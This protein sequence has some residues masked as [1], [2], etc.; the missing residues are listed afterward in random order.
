MTDRLDRI[1]AA[2]A[3][4]KLDALLIGA[5]VEDMFGRH[6]DNRRYVSGFTGSTGWALVTPSQAL[7]AA[8][9]RYTEQAEREVAPRGFT[10]FPA[11]GTSK[12]WWPKLFG[13]ARLAG[14][15]VGVSRSDISLASWLALNERIE[16]MPSLDRPE[17][18]AAPLIV[19][20]LRRRKDPEELVLLQHA[21]DIADQAFESLQ[22][23]LTP[24]MT[25]L[26]AAAIFEQNVLALGA[27]SIS[28]ETIVA[29]GPRAAMP[30]AKP[31]DARL[32]EGR[33]IVV[34]MGAQY[35][36]YCSDLTRTVVLGQPDP[37]FREIFEIVFEAQRNAIEHVEAGMSGV[38]AHNLAMDVIAAHG[39]GERFGHG[40]G[41]GVGMQVHE[42][43]YLGL[44]SEDTLEE[45]M[46][47]TI[48][49]GIYLPGWGGVRIEDIVVLESGR[50]RVLSH[51]HKL[52][53]AGAT[54]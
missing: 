39:Y 33:T 41:H 28:F 45:G 4:A 12:D 27:E 31:T 30:H 11:L 26:E 46:V 13:E 1:R 6:D 2:I 50:A 54:L 18:V 40:L 34:D 10:V 53:P 22:V 24:E 25:E 5:A 49:P 47:F 35:R 42:S 3:E 21:I 38:A 51:A 43:P 20:N 36:H 52:T 37:K 44:S 7:F 32:G 9:F 8:D 29:A 19:E 14:K 48:E 15:K 17:L 23:R 16:D